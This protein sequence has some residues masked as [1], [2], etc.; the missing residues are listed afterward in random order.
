MQTYWVSSITLISILCNKPSSL[1]IQIPRSVVVEAKIGIELLAG[2]EVVVV[3]RACSSDQVAEGI[4]SV[5]VGDR[6][7]GIGEL[8]YRTVAV[9][10]VE[11]DT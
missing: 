7:G 6:T 8:S 10:L 5:C 4:V 1:D 2:V 3:C 11:V 9:V